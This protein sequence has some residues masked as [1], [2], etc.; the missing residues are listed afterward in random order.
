MR[1][2]LSLI[3]VNLLLTSCG[4]I[5]GMA[6]SES[7]RKFTDEEQAQNFFNSST[8]ECE[9]GDCPQA[10]GGLYTYA[11]Q[12]ESYSVGSCSLT[13]ISSNTVITNRHCL[14]EDIEKAGSSC[15]NRIRI[16]LPQA[17]GFPTET[18]ECDKVVAAS[19]HYPQTAA[20]DWSVLKFKGQTK[21]KPIQKN[22]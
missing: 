16:I 3:V 21:R 17:E 18:Y 13:L 1:I 7:T 12:D 8:I 10:I 2:I 15:F 11:G 22:I 4:L 6:K 9:S 20:P 19:L 14:P 5:D